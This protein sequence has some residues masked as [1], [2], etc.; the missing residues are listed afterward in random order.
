MAPSRQPE[1]NTLALI[2]R[3]TTIAMHFR[4][5][6]RP[7][8]WSSQDHDSPASGTRGTDS[9]R[10]MKLRVGSPHAHLTSSFRHQVAPPRNLRVVQGRLPTPRNRLRTMGPGRR[11][12]FSQ[13]LEEF[14]VACLIFDLWNSA[15]YELSVI[16]SYRKF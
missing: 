10:N 15:G 7:A 5:D 12:L 1:I 9:I 11:G 8:A 6:K 14:A 16:P 2:R 4:P 3:D 13:G